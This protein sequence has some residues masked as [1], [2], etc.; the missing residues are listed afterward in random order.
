MKNANSYWLDAMT[1]RL[2][3]SL[4]KRGICIQITDLINIHEHFHNNL[5]FHYE[6]KKYNV[7]AD[8][9]GFTPIVITKNQN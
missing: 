5:P 9:I 4:M 6:E 3:H 8:V 1:Q 7:S 2:A